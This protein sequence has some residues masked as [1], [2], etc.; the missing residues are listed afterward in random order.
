MKTV[1]YTALRYGADYLGYAIRSVI[2]HVDEYHVLYATQPSHGHPSDAICPDIEAELHEIAWQAAGSKLQWHRGDWNYEGQQRGA[3]LELVPDAD[4]IISLDSDEIWGDE[5]AEE[6]LRFAMDGSVRYWRCMMVHYWRSFH[7]AI[8]CDP[9]Y[10]VRVT[11]PKYANGER[12][13]TSGRV[14]MSDSIFNNPKNGYWI[15]HFGYATTPEIVAYKWQ[16]HGH[17]DE[18]RHDINWFQDVFM[19]NRQ[20]DCHPVGSEWWNPETVNCFDYMPHWMS[21]HPFFGM[22]VIE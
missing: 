13:F 15:N 16:I 22:K 6:V 2:N 12:T 17:K 4:A 8:P 1:A 20:Y 7:K 11:I 18:L 5:L 21:E 10:P 14:A 9:A 3:I 19:A